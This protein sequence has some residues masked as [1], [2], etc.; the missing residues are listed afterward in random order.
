MSGFDEPPAPRDPST[1]KPD[2]APGGPPNEGGVGFAAIPLSDAASSQTQAER[3]QAAGRWA[4]AQ[5]DYYIRAGVS[6]GPGSPRRWRRAG[7]SSPS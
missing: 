4:E 1:N 3:E 5:A 7:R 2:A 6:R